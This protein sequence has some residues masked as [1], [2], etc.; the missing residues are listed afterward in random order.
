[1]EE[2]CEGLVLGNEQEE[3]IWQLPGLLMEEECE[4]LV[5]GNEQEG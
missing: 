4:G 3:Y 5:L 2:E 1:M